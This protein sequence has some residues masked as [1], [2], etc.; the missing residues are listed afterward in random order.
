MPQRRRE[1]RLDVRDIA[2]VAVVVLTEPGTKHA[3][4]AYTLSGPEALT[5]TQVAEK[6]SAAVGKPI[7]Y[8]DPPEAEYR[9]MLIGVGIPGPYATRSSTCAGTTPREGRAR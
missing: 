3:G 2:A 7:R 8:I 9:K 6:L 4:K 5:F 1:S